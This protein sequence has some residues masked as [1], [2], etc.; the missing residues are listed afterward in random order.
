MHAAYGLLVAVRHICQCRVSTAGGSAGAH[1]MLMLALAR[2]ENMVAQTPL[3]EAI[4][5]PTAA[6]MQQPPMASTLL[7]RPDLIAS[8][9]L[10]CQVHPRQGTSPQYAARPRALTISNPVSPASYSQG[11]AG[12]SCGTLKI[13]TTTRKCGST[14]CPRIDLCSNAFASRRQAE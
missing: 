4:C 3:R 8:A 10:P 11:Q 5:C 9:N 13:C 1:L 12:D 7:M 14:I 2:A 6:R